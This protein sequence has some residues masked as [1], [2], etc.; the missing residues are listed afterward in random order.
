MFIKL[1]VAVS[2]YGSSDS[3]V[4]DGEHRRTRNES[5]RTDRHAATEDDA[6]H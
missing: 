5:P 2:A 4:L 6:R 3:P 1:S